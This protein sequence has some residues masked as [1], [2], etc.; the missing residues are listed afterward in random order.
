M[1]AEARRLRACA[2]PT[3]TARGLSSASSELR[4]FVGRR[5][6]NAED[7]DDITQQAMA[8]ACA[9]LRQ[10]RGENPSPWLLAIARNLIADYYRAQNRYYFLELDEALAQR[11]PALQTSAGA[12]AA[13]V[14]CRERLTEVL[15]RIAGVCLEHQVAV[16]LADVYGHCDRDSAAALR[17]SVACFKLLLHRARARVRAIAGRFAEGSAA[18]PVGGLGVTCYLSPGELLWLRDDLLAGLKLR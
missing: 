11:E 5:V 9:E 14:E 16:L 2:A 15:H 8:V 7:A 3:N 1:K 18:A 17:M 6:S 13:A 10:F 12:S 4:V